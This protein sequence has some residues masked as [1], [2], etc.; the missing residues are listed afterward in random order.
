[1]NMFNILLQAET[2][3]PG[4]PWVLLLGMFIIM[5]F[6]M[7]RPQQKRQKEAKKFRDTISKGDKVVTIGGVHGKIISISDLT[8]VLEVESGKIRVSKSA[9][10]PSGS[11]EAEEVK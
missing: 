7:I 5:Y 10:S 2:A 11:P 9:L 3:E 6:F 4:F 1:M 8:V